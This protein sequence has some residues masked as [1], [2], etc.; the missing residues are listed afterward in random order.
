ME[1][2]RRRIF[3]PTAS[4]AGVAEFKYHDNTE[5]PSALDLESCARE[6]PCSFNIF[7]VSLSA[8]TYEDHRNWLP[9][10]SRQVKSFSFITNSCRASGAF[11]A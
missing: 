10:G 11:S 7:D 4:P 9:E 1:D 2:E 5:H 8:E 3:R 6:T